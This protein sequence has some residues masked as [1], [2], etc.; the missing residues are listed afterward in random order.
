MRYENKTHCNMCNSKSK[1]RFLVNHMTEGK[2]GS[3]ATNEGL[4]KYCEIETNAVVALE[5]SCELIRFKRTVVWYST[6]QFN[7]IWN[8]Y[9]SHTFLR[10]GLYTWHHAWNALR[11]IWWL[12]WWGNDP[13]KFVCVCWCQSRLFFNFFPINDVRG[14][15]KNRG[16]ACL[17]I[18]KYRGRWL[19]KP[20]ITKWV[21]P[22]RAAKWSSILFPHCSWSWSWNHRV[23]LIGNYRK[24]SRALI[25]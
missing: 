6:G 14:Y 19:T 9:L 24:S 18:E 3:Y 21:S 2:S 4:V 17:M 16:R 15:K 11:H 10:A 7:I 12:F 8:Q 22:G 13:F 23:H 1:I 5:N 20:Q 25:A